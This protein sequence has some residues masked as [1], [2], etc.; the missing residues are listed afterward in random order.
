MEKEIKE[1]YKLPQNLHD[2]IYKKI[3]K[4]VFYK[5]KTEEQPIAIIVGGQSGAGKGAVISYSKNEIEKEGKDIVIITTDEYKPYHPQAIE[6]AK[7]YPTDYVEIIDQDAGLWTGQILKKAIDEKYNFIFE[8]TLKNDRIMDRIN[9]LNQ[10][11]FKVIVR[12]LAVPEL[13][14]LL[15]VHERYEKQIE[16]IGVGRLISVERHNNAYIGVP[17][18]VD[19]IEKS[20]LCTVEIFKRGE[21]INEPQK[22]YSSDAKDERYPTARIALEECRKSEK[23]KTQ[24]NAKYRIEKLRKAYKDRNATDKEMQELEKVEEMLDK[25]MEQEK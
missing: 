21:K 20:G 9:E 8:A 3:E 5:S 24:E 2:E 4:E 12:A 22:I 10:Q 7:I 1:K 23:Y 25:S 19:K 18:V 11:G 13:E 17:Q 14:S 15:S 16:N 6:I